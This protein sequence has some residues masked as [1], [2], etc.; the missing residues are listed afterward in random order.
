MQS[1]C[2]RCMTTVRN[3]STTVES[4]FSLVMNQKYFIRRIISS[5]TP[6]LFLLSSTAS[7]PILTSLQSSPTL[8][9]YGSFVLFSQGTLIIP[10]PRLEFPAIAN[11]RIRNVRI[12]CS[13]IDAPPSWTV[14]GA[15]AAL[16]AAIDSV[17]TSVALTRVPL[18]SCNGSCH[19]HVPYFVV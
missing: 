7:K 18:Y 1:I 15:V 4:D 17:S 14:I 10:D 13:A 2:Y 5:S 9:Y 11:F 19:C 3:D 8:F 12:P 6:V 16:Y